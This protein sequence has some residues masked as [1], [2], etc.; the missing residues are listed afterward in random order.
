VQA[1]DLILFNATWVQIPFDY[2]FQRFYRPGTQ[3][4]SQPDS[5][6]GE[7]PETQPEEQSGKQPG[8]HPP[9]PPAPLPVVQHGVPV[10]LFDAGVLEPKMTPA[11]LPR[12]QS[13]LEGHDRVWL[14]YSHD[15][16]TDPQG[17]IPAALDAELEL[18]DSQ[19]FNGLQ[20]QRY[21]VP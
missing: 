18:T 2:Y 21:E 20:V 19:Q 14:V 9:T 16:Y 4:E 7:Q 8:S 15:W 13:L 17:L 5:Q 6:R 1:G 3:P 10:D 12:L 11:D